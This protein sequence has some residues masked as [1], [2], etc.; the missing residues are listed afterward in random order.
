ME[1]LANTC[2]FRWKKTRQ[3]IWEHMRFLLSQKT[4]IFLHLWTCH[5]QPWYDTFETSCFS[6]LFISTRCVMSPNQHVDFAHFENY[7]SREIRLAQLQRFFQKRFEGHTSFIVK[8]VHDIL[9]P[10][11]LWYYPLW[12]IKLGDFG[13]FG[14]LPNFPKLFVQNTVGGNVHHR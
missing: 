9:G 6:S 5:I 10:W 3:F 7:Q 13:R 1:N 14:D 2:W 4:L 12:L 8:K 11:Q